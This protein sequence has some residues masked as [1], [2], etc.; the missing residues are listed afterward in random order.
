MG[1]RPYQLAPGAYTEILVGNNDSVVSEL[2]QAK[3][4][5]NLVSRFRSTK[6]HELKRLENLTFT[7]RG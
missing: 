1:F 4:A 7:D 2:R 5:C 6:S 3:T